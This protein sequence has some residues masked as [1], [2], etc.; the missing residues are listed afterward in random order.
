MSTWIDT[1]AHL[2]DA[3]FAD[4]R[5]T[6]I[7]GARAL[8]VEQIM[9]IGY[10]PASWITTLALARRVPMIVP[11][12]GLHP[13]STEQWSVET[14]AALSKLV[15]QERPAAIGEIGLDYFW[16]TDNKIT[17][18]ES[19]VAQI[20][21]A[22]KHD[23]PIVIHQRGAGDDVLDVL[24]D[25]PDPLTVILHSFDGH[26]GLARLCLERGWFLGVGGLSTRRQN[27]ALRTLLAIFPLDFL[28][29]E[30]D[31]PYLVPSGIKSR[32]NTPA[33]IPVI[34]ERLAGLR[35]ID[36]EMVAKQTTA[37]VQRA[38]GLRIPEHAQ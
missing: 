14:F 17:Q 25:Q 27:E 19:F 29:L 24:R 28:I 26:P 3:Q 30:T 12:L 8:G 5:D 21:L 2:D 34:G 1:H 22:R 6:V 35:G 7:A 10:D 15:V 23:L 33:S 16:Q 18:L 9:N 13:G 31:S 37:N 20:G 36:I 4:D 11:V 38:F 32:R